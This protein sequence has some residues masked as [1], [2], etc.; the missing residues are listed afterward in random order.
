MEIFT[1]ESGRAPLLVSLPH[2]GSHI[3]DALAARMTPAARTAPDTDWFVSRLYAF[4][5]ELGASILRPNHSRYVVDLNRPPDD[6][7]LYPGQNTTGLCPSVRFTGEP[8]YLPGQE[9]DAA[10]VAARVERYWRP[11]HDALADEL[12]RLRA[13]FGRA[14]LWDGHSIRG[15]LPF[16]FEGRLPDLNLGTASGTS[17]T[18]A[19]QARLASVLASQTRYSHVINGRFK[20]G[21]ITRHYGNPARGVEAIQLELAQSTYMDE[22]ATSYLPERAERL[23]RIVLRPLLEAA[24]G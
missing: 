9:P 5:R 11:Y 17:C 12:A 21:Y 23:E 14:L 24:L 13:R 1:L 18:P 7:S 4:A 10:E 8:V 19:L 3:P 16:L 20:G 15:E 22:G 2:D 6:V